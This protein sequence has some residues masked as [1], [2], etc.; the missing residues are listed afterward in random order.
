MIILLVE[1]LPVTFSRVK[2]RKLF[3]TNTFI[4]N[5]H[6]YSHRCLEINCVVSVLAQF[7]PKKTIMSQNCALILNIEWATDYS[8]LENCSWSKSKVINR[9][10]IRLRHLFICL[11]LS[12]KH[13]GLCCISRYYTFHYFL[14][15]PIFC[16][17]I[18]DEVLDL[19]I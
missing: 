1:H 18:F 14:S 2:K 17:G 5:F 15:K 4:G 11:Y 12:I 13:W 3:F 10:I 19:L 16:P 9:R 8:C 6:S 7:Y